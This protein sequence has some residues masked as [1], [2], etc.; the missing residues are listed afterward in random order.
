MDAAIPWAVAKL[1]VVAGL[2][3]SGK[4]AVIKWLAARLAG[5]EQSPAYVR[6][7]CHEGVSESP[8]VPSELARSA[9]TARV[10]PDHFLAAEAGKL[11]E[12]AGAEADLLLVETAGLCAR[13]SP[14][15]DAAVGVFVAD[16]SMGRSAI[17]KVGPMLATADV[18]VLTHIDRVSAA[19]A[20]MAAQAA[21]RVNPRC[22]VIPLNGLTGEGAVEL[23]AEL[24]QRLAAVQPSEQTRYATLRASPPQFYC[25][26][27]MGQHRVAVFEA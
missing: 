20:A 11:V 22:M 5:A 27:C 16:L 12:W 1:V 18:C 3:S 15:P 9:V 23:S 6:V 2:A 25:S 19:E 17:Q 13:C 10:C 26:Y 24:V 8:P 21:S 4:S 7:Y 14:F